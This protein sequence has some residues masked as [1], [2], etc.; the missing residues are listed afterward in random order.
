MDLECRTFDSA[1]CLPRPKGGRGEVAAC[2]GT[3]EGAENFFQ[4]LEN[5]RK[6]FPIVGKPAALLLRLAA[7]PARAWAGKGMPGPDEVVMQR[8][9]PVWPMWR[10]V[11]KE[12]GAPHD[13]TPTAL[14][15]STEKL[16]MSSDCASRKP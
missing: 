14:L 7:T 16:T 13:R 11:E 5:R 10:D 1:V 4:S 8:Q 9:G 2:R 12:K 15:I 3:G 6:I